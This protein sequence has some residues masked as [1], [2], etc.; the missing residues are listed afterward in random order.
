MDSGTEEESAKHIRR[1]RIGKIL[2]ILGLI[3]FMGYMGFLF[4]MAEVVFTAEANS[5]QISTTNMKFILSVFPY[6][7]IFLFFMM[8]IIFSG[9]YLTVS[10]IENITGKKRREMSL[11]E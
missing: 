2:R 1:Y 8:I 10:S 5:R 6:F 9:S 11:I 4:Y 3:P 7:S